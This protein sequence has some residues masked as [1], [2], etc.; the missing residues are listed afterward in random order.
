MQAAFGLAEAGPAAGAG[1]LAGQH[2][3]RAMRA[4]DAGIA[5]VMQR[6]VVEPALVDVAPHLLRCPVGERVDFDQVE[7]GVPSE[8]LR[9]GTGGGLFA[10]DAGDPGTQSRQLAAQRLN[11]AQVAA[12]VG[13]GGPERRA[14][15]S[16]LL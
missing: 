11:L 9:R 12:G 1:V 5:A 16:F 4:A 8:F 2:G 15:A 14:M 10:A 13:I 6:V 3:A 7:L